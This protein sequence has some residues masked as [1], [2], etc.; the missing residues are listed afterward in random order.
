MNVGIST[1]A[2]RVA[3]LKQER[4]G[5]SN[6]EGV[7]ISLFGKDVYVRKASGSLRGVNSLT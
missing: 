7:G 6:G 2:K 1:M 5:K 3:Q 4:Q